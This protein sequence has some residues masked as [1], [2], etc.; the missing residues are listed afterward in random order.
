MSKTEIVFEADLETIMTE[1]T[2]TLGKLP[3]SAIK[4]HNRL[5]LVF[6][7]K[8]SA[9]EIEKVNASVSKFYPNFKSKVKTVKETL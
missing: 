3:S 4:K 2:K 5:H 9:S 1:L 7:G 6:D 8:L